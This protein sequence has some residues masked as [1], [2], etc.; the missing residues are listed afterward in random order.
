MRKPLPQPKGFISRLVANLRALLPEDWRGRAGELFRNT[1]Q[2]IAEFAEE[3]K[4]KP[5]DLADEG[6][7][8]GRRK[9]EGLAN[10][11]FAAALKDFADTERIRV[12][13]ELQRRS[14]ESEVKKKEEEARLTGI[15]RLT[16]EVELLKKIK[17]IGVV[18]RQDKDGNLTALP[19]PHHSAF[20]AYIAAKEQKLLSASEEPE[21]NPEK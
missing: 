4:I 9:L 10:K 11:E 1:T 17:E 19:D 14:L 3:H 20:D 13:A 16:A 21:P 18:L 12:E 2:E 7:T 15:Q 6:I 5:R 8:L